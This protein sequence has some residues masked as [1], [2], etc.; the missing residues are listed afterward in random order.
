MTTLD[1]AKSDE[2]ISIKVPARVLVPFVIAL[3]AAIGSPWA[4]DFYSRTESVN[5][6]ALRVEVDAI[7]VNADA[8][9][10]QIEQMVLEQKETNRVLNQLLGA[11]RG[12]PLEN[13]P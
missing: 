10:R 7:K 3:M 5:V 8:R 4:V 11:V 12:L 1:L 6:L 2:S 13:R 9:G